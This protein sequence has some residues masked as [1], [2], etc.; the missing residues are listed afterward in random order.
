M[1]SHLFDK[2]WREYDK[3]Y[4][5]NQAVYKSELRAVKELISSGTGLEIGV[6]TGRFASPF[7]VEFGVDPSLNM[8]QLAKKRGIKA[9][10]GKGEEL[11]F[12]DESFHCILIVVTICFLD[13][14][15]KVIREARRTLK[16]KG[17]LIIGMIN[18][19]SLV[20]AEYQ[21]KREKSIFYRHAHFL[22]PEKILEIFIET[23]F[24]FIDSRQ[25][26]FQSLK[27]STKDETP[28]KGYNKGGFIVLKAQ[29]I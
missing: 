20:G 22:Y 23:G 19:N 24:Q 7:H 9:V 25:T 27:K 15:V 21:K 26:L 17:Y 29:K 13:D 6:G 11:P 2:N 1:K 10:L 5:N 14:V 18:K 16:K 28:K 8:L 12:K 3:W 4:Q